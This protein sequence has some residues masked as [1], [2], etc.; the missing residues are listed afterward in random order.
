MAK[1]SL[2]FKN[3]GSSNLNSVGVSSGP[4]VSVLTLEADFVTILPGIICEEEGY[5]FSKIQVL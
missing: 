5:P 2:P 3:I 1:S 4:V